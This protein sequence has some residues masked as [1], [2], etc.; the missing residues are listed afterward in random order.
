MKGVLI[1]LDNQFIVFV[2]P[3]FHTNMLGWVHG[4]Q[5]LNHRV[6]VWVRNIGFSENYTYG[7]PI[8]IMTEQDFTSKFSAY[9]AQFSY[10]KALY[11]KILVTK[12][13]FLILRFESDLI[14]L[15]LLVGVLFSRV[16]FMLYIQQ[17]ILGLSFRHQLSRL[18]FSRILKIPIM[19]PVYSLK[20]EWCG[21]PNDHFEYK[22][23]HFIP[24]AVCQFSLLEIDE[25][26]NNDSSKINFLSIG[27]F[28]ERKNHLKVL[29][30][31]S[32]NYLFKKTKST[33]T[34]V[35]EVSNAEHILVQKQIQLF[36]AENGFQ[37][38]VKIKINLNH[39]E[40]LNEIA[41][42]DV[43][44][45]MSKDEPAS[46]SNIE[47]M[48]QGK[49]VVVGSGN[50]TSNYMRNG[51]GGFIVNDFYELQKKVTYLMSEPGFKESAGQENMAVIEKLSNP[52]VVA[53]KLL[54]I[55]GDL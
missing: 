55:L 37:E 4:L 50:G 13:N 5:A 33:L 45:L 47:A 20:D 2:V 44:L 39:F 52:L 7:H 51:L 23:I 19:T 22:H 21:H 43:F 38:V 11:R 48:S 40:T 28:Q 15:L 12:P 36:I 29:Q 41:K 27:K 14:S 16:P 18:L 30:S 35:G 32:N 34:L 1:Y 31:L 42:S 49:S 9:F 10:L 46:F 24:F 3:R 6:E 54:S 53:Q 8:R 25:P 26:L 17:P